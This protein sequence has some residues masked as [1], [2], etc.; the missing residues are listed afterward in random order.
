MLMILSGH[1]IY[2]S[3]Y[4]LH[5]HKLCINNVYLSRTIVLL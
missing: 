2:V 1:G 5:G 4:K 3:L